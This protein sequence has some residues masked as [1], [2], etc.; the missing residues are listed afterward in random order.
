[1]ADELTPQQ[2]STLVAMRAARVEY[3]HGNA[4][5]VCPH[6]KHRHEADRYDAFNG[7]GDRFVNCHGCGRTFHLS[8]TV[9]VTYDSSPAGLCPDCDRW[10]R[11]LPGRRVQGHERLAQDRWVPCPG[12]GKEPKEK[13]NA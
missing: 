1:M 11:L 3:E 8:Y 12:E 9:E 7:D 10:V 5:P 13:A 6:C 2:L 4:A